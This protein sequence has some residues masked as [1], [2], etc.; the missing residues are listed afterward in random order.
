MHVLWPSKPDLPKR[1][2]FSALSDSD[3]C[4]APASF[5]WCSSAQDWALA[6]AKSLDQ[7]LPNP[8]APTCS[9]V[10][11]RS[12]PAPCTLQGRTTRTDSA[13]PVSLHRVP[14]GSMGALRSFDMILQSFGIL[15][16][17]AL[18]SGPPSKRPP[19]LITRCW[20]KNPKETRT[21]W[22]D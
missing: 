16:W 9:L 13:L 5:G 2:T 11:V 8:A 18:A 17:F 7:G 19:A 14:R 21:N 12:L 1:M 4:L 3:S 15:V 22:S 20:G 6:S 10:S